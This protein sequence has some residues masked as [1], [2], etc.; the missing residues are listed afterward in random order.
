MTPDF[1][2]QE[3][4]LSDLRQA[5]AK[6]GLDAFLVPRVDEHRGEYV[7]PS[8]ERLQWLTGFAGSA[9]QAVVLADKAAL[10]VD[11]RYTLQA[12]NEASEALYE[13]RQIPEATV[14]AFLEAELSAGQT[15]GF[16]PW[17]HSLAERRRL[18]A[19]AARCGAGLRAV[20]KNPLDSIWTDRP[21][22]PRAPA[23]PHPLTFAGEK[24]LAKRERL[25]AKLK[26]QG[27][28]ASILSLPD[29]IA[30]L[31][32]VRGAD[33]ARTPFVLSFA[34]LS[35]EGDVSWFVAPEKVSPNLKAA[36]DAGITLQQP[37]ALAGALAALNGKRV[38][39]E[40][41]SIPAWI[42]TALE[43]AG[44]TLIEGEDPCQAPKAAKNETEQEGARN[45]HKRDGIALTRFLAWFAQESDQRPLKELECSDRLE[46]FR[47]ETNQ[48]RDLSFDTIAGSGANGAIVHY[49]VSPASDRSIAAGELMVLDSGGQYLDGTTDVTRTLVVGNPAEEE[50]DRFTRVLKGHIALATARFPPGT[51]GSQLDVLAR[52][53]LWAVGL[54][55]DHGTGHG[56]GSYLSVHEG[57]QRISKVP[58]RVALEPG[59]IVS[60]EPGYY[61]AGAYGIRIE[62]LVMVVES[63]AEEGEERPML[64][65][66]T[67]T[68][69]PLERKL[70][71]TSLLTQEEIIWVDDYHARVLEEV[72][73]SLEGKDLAF[74]QQACA[75]LNV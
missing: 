44:A 60:N 15:L 18:E 40:A 51:S 47:R 37:D 16:D 32:N 22:P 30:W 45:A 61:K 6:E 31:L 35:Q 71:E 65:F 19:L 21:A 24:S 67:L 43:E 54:D 73:S 58:N 41:T 70:I 38:L 1:P 72:G 39:V 26:E 52:R 50:R 46:A 11:G 28:D 64:A 9:G 14:D 59:M 63:A 2:T 53:P 5:L 55:Y 4:R 57:P 62:N 29:S 56:V 75:P 25:G 42:A 48:L 3:S 20:E 8:A 74:L 69:A 68:L 10:F 33:V 17:L 13:I 12:A 7:P 66:E 49:R 23:E 36:L 27:A 34:I